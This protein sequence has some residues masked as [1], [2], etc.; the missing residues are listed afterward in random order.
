MRAIIL[1]LSALLFTACVTTPAPVRLAQETPIQVAVVVDQPGKLESGEV[2]PELVTALTQALA[3]RNLAPTFV[4]IEVI[5]TLVDL[6]R[7]FAKL[8]NHSRT[9]KSVQISRRF[10]FV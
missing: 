9:F 2:P 7:K 5:F 1:S 3:K 4:D 6:L 10:L 8:Q